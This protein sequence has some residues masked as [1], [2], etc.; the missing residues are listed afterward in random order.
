MAFPDSIGLSARPPVTAQCG[1]GR[2]D[3][4]VVPHDTGQTGPIVPCRRARLTVNFR[5]HKHPL[6]L[7]DLSLRQRRRLPTG[8]GSNDLHARRQIPHPVPAP[9]HGK[10][11]AALW[12]CRKAYPRASASRR[13]GWI[14]PRRGKTPLQA[15]DKRYHR[16][17]E[18]RR[19]LTQHWRRCSPWGDR[20]AAIPCSGPISNEA[21]SKPAWTKDESGHDE[22]GGPYVNLSVDSYIRRGTARSFLRD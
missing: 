16:A 21:N 9:V 7:T 20:P 17:A 3:I 5:P 18:P 22:F 4:A 2:P 12:L 13:M 1:Y 19:I 11:S 6:P 8:P 14:P 10:N 15:S